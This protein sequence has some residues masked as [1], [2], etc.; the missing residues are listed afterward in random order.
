MKVKLRDEHPSAYVKVSV[1][2]AILIVDKR[3]K[4]ISDEFA[5][6]FPE[7]TFDVEGVPKKKEEKEQSEG[8]LKKKTKKSV[9]KKK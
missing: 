5:S 2:G 4:E 8:F 3:F 9:T 6:F 7:Q 1:P